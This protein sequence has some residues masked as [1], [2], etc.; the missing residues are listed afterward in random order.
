VTRGLHPARRRFGVV[1]REPAK[2][3][4][5]PPYRW[6]QPGPLQKGLGSMPAIPRYKV[7]A[8][9]SCKPWWQVSWK[10]RKQTEWPALYPDSP[11][12]QG[13]H[14][15]SCL[16]MSAMRNEKERR[17]AQGFYGCVG[18]DLRVRPQ[19]PVFVLP[20]VDT[21]VH[22]YTRTRQIVATQNPVAVLH[23]PDVRHQAWARPSMDHRKH[24]KLLA[25]MP[26]RNP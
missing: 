2:R 9:A 19:V 4:S 5:W 6:S 22:P 11:T 24:G 3:C 20:R 13:P 15:T 7:V 16:L 18:A 21:E 17:R 12:A 25:R 26:G 10:T 1:P 14:V 23:V 8:T